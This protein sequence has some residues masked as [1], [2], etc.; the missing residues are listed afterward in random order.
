MELSIDLFEVSETAL[1]E[2]K[3]TQLFPTPKPRSLNEVITAYLRMLKC[4]PCPD[5]GS[6][7]F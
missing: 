6:N 3:S 4:P 7:F 1:Q 2:K 5:H